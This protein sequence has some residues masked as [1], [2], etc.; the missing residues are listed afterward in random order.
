MST[1][2]A[3][4]A[5]GL[6][7]MLAKTAA[8]TAPIAAFDFDETCIHG[9]ISETWLTYLDELEPGRMAEYRAGCKADRAAAYQKLAIEL[10]RGL[11]RTEVATLVE[12]AFRRGIA[13]GRIAL[14]PS[15]HQLVASMK[16]HGW[17][18]WVV[19]ASPTPVVQTVAV[20][21]GIDPE[22]VIGMTS[23]LGADHRYLPEL[24]QP[25][26]FR[27]GKLD[28][29]LARTGRA[30][31]FAAGDTDGDLWLLNA[32]Q[33]ALLIDHGER[34]DPALRERARQA[35]WWIQRGWG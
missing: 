3:S 32:A 18:V 33:Y 24:L 15:I 20:N 10:V 11:T 23:P 4:I 21:Y 9:D 19:T 26:T 28:A 1:W 16:H 2:E 6:D 7:D 12:A 31:T 30:P 14:R 17:E 5:I 25:T 13:E 22:R 34:T 29:L 35:G 8:G 27:E